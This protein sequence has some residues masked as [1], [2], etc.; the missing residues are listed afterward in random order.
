MLPQALDPIGFIAVYACQEFLHIENIGQ[1]LHASIFRL[2][3]DG[4]GGIRPFKFINLPQ[5]FFRDIP[6]GPSTLS[7][8]L[9]TI[10]GMTIP[11]L[12]IK[13]NL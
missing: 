9:G 4:F 13:T 6:N 11:G 3:L 12:G 5:L 8:E 10:T 1:R 7:P 2:H